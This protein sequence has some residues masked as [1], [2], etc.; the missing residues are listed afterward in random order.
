MR[1]CLILLLLSAMPFLRGSAQETALPPLS[2][3]A[4][5]PH[6]MQGDHPF[7]WL[8]GTAW[9]L[10]HRTTL[11][12]ARIYLDDRAAKGF[13]VV[14]TVVLAEEN[15][16]RAPSSNG[17]LPLIDEDPTQP[18]ERYFAY[19][20]TILREAAQRG[21]YV[22]L[23]PTWGDKWNLAWGQGPEVF[24][25][26][27]AEIFGKHLGERYR[28]QT[29]VLWVLGGDRWPEDDEDRAIINAT[30]RGI[31]AGGATQLMTYHPSGG[32]LAS[33]H[34][35]EP[36][37]DFDFFQTGHDADVRDEDF[38]KTARE[39]APLRPAVNGEPLYDNHP[40]KF[41]PTEHGWLD[42]VDVRRKFYR[43]MLRGAAG[44]TYGA[45][46]IWQMW[47]PGRRP[48]NG[49]RQSWKSALHLPGSTQVG[50]GRAFLEQYDWWRLTDF[51]DIFETPPGKAQDQ[52]FAAWIANEIIFVYLPEGAP[53]RLKF[54]AL[55]KDGRARWTHQW[56]NPRDGSLVPVDDADGDPYLFTP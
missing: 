51:P 24:T 7:F 28:D 30:A 48:V 42:A 56:F 40:N 44:F 23:L 34:F 31:R 33:D 36:W 1:T 54:D 6:L 27:N 5:G 38:V 18:N 14:Q 10:L 43:S 12:E 37:L 32:K 25:P 41:K 15:G 17:E 13:N 55:A 49:V 46:D 16:L 11:D 20:D 21:M 4:D 39:R 29:N 50:L 26:E 53:V 35:D 19:V 22:A 45:H 47:L 8:G 52:P 2:L 9:E 3:S